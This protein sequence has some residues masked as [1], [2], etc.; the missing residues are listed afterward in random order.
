MLM[1]QYLKE[2][3]HFTP[4]NTICYLVRGERSRMLEIASKFEINLIKD[5]NRKER[6]TEASKNKAQ[7]KLLK[8]VNSNSEVEPELPKEITIDDDD[9]S[10]DL[11]DE[12]NIICL[13]DGENDLDNDFKPKN[14]KIKKN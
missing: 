5:S 13:D 12:D 1:K 9:D 7:P 11:Y 8:N 6:V 3:F 2:D 4:Y 14:K 10:S